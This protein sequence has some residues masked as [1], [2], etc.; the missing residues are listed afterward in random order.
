MVN[1]NDMIYL[2]SSFVIIFNTILFS[3]SLNL[4]SLSEI[5]NMNVEQKYQILKLLL[6][7]FDFLNLIP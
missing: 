1:S 7:L 6:L 5:Y 4:I 2:N 3:S